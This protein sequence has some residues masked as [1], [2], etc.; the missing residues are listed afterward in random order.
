M[1]IG[2]AYIR[3]S[4]DMQLELSPES[5]LKAI[6]DYAAAHDII[7]SNEYIYHDDGIS[8]RKAEKRPEFMRMI[9]TAK[10]K[11][12]PFDVI[13]I[14][15]FSR[16]AR[17]RE[18]SIVYKSMLRKQCG[19]DVVSITEQLSDDKTSILIEA[20]LEAMDEY[21]SV[22]LAEEV[23]RGMT[24]K[25][26][27]GGVVS[28][29]PY[30][31][32]MGIGKFEPDPERADIVRQIYARFLN[33][34]RTLAIA[35]WLNSVGITTKHGKTF[36]NRSVEY[37][38][39]NPVY[40]GK[41]RWTKTGSAT[42]SSYYRANE[43]TIIVDGPHTP[44]ISAQDFASVQDLMEQQRRK[45]PKHAS[46][47]TAM[48]MVKGL[49]RCSSCGATMTASCGIK[50]LQCYRYTH[51]QCAVSHYIS[52]KKVN[53]AL[54]DA[55]HADSL[56]DRILVKRTVSQNSPAD[57]DLLKAQ[58]KR[59]YV[60]L[61]RIKAAYAD[62][63]DTLEEYKANKQKIS[64]SIKA[65]EAQCLSAQEST[66]EIYVDVR[67]RISQAYEIA[68][69][70]NIPEDLKNSALRELIEKIVYD[71]ETKSLKIFYK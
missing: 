49:L 13:L 71:S 26:E 27:K 43:D 62:G 14:W 68:T 15:K 24:E 69:N 2:A 32:I 38:L 40:T 55:L 65:L 35:K 10:T 67:D 22:N 36:T 39:T 21:Y 57:I 28:T 44:L 30:G 42:A 29:P 34:D 54:I 37:I 63:I 53:A 1:K 52:L 17:N 25:A 6:R 66:K 58:L 41:L 20:L 45:Y 33:G 9:A 11:P 64:K 5:Q 7:L 56:S 51:G 16:F 70:D 12:K 46:Q 23:K 4:T 8:G 19:I 31:Y 50:G 59:E 47:S 61:D 3:V 48:Y 18:D 60:K